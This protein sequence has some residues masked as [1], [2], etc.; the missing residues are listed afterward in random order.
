MTNSG[1]VRIYELSRDLGLPSR[2]ILDA[3]ETRS[4]SVKSHSSSISEGQAETIIGHLVAEGHLTKDLAATYK[5][6]VSRKEK[7]FGSDRPGQTQSASKPTG[8]SLKT[9]TGLASRPKKPVQPST[10]KPNLVAVRSD[11]VQGKDA[12]NAPIALKPSPAGPKLHKKPSKPSKEPASSRPKLVSTSENKKDL[13]RPTVIKAVKAKIV[14]QPPTGKATGKGIAPKGKEGSVVVKPPSVEAKPPQKPKLVRPTVVKPATP[15]IA[16]RSPGV[17]SAKEVRTPKGKASP[18]VVRSSSVVGKPLKPSAAVKRQVKKLTPQGSPASN[19]RPKETNPREKVVSPPVA[20]KPPQLMAP[21]KPAAPQA[22]VNEKPVRQPR[23]RTSPVSRTSTQAPRPTKDQRLRPGSKSTT[24]PPTK[25]PLSAGPSPSRPPQPAKKVVEQHQPPRR[26]SAK[27]PRSVVASGMPRSR[28]SVLA[29]RPDGTRSP[30]SKSTPQAQPPV[31]Q[32]QIVARRPSARP[33]DSDTSQRTGAASG[34]AVAVRSSPAGS[35]RRPNPTEPRSSELLVGRPSRRPS[36]GGPPGVSRPGGGA[37]P[38]RLQGGLPPGVRRPAAPSEVL[39]KE[40][41]AGS[42]AT[43]SRPKQDPKTKT[44]AESP[45]P[46]RRPGPPRG[47]APGGRRPGPGGRPRRQDWDDSARLDQLQRGGA[48][49]KQ[50]TKVHIIGIHDEDVNAGEGF[51]S[52]GSSAVLSASLARPSVKP[53]GATGQPAIKTKRRKKSKETARQR[54]R[55]RAMEL[56][57]ARE[58]K[59]QRPEMLVVPEGNLTV[60]ELAEALGVDSSDIIKSLFFKGISATVTQSLDLPA[61]EKVAEEFG[62]PVVEDDIEAAAK[63]TVAMI[64]DEDLENLSRRPPVVTVMGHVDHGKTSLLDAIRSTRVAAGEAGGITQHIGAYQVEVV[65]EEKP[66]L[67]TFLDTPGHEAF[68]AMRARGTKVT[69]IAVLVVAADDGVR[70]QTI[71]AISHARA[72]EVPI[73]VAINKVDKE[74]ANPDRVRQELADHGLTSEEWGGET[75]MVPVSALRGENIDK[76]LE[77]ILL[78][79][80]IEDLQANPDRLAR[81]TVVEAHLDKAKGPVA[82]LLVQNGTLRPGDVI[83]AGPVLGKIR[84]MVNDRGDRLMEALPSAAVEALGFSEVPTAGDAFEVF[85]DEKAARAVVSDRV[86]DARAARLAQQMASR[87][88]SLTALSDQAAEGELKELNLILK[89][90]VQGSLEAILGSL[91]QLSQEEVQIR[92]LLSSPGEITE[93]DIDLATASGAVVIGFNTSMASGARRAAEAASVDVRNYDVI[94][95]MLEDIQGA[96]EGLLEPEL[97]EEPLGWAEVR[98][99]FSIGNGAVAGCY[100]TE[101]KLQRNCQ[102]RV[103]RG[104]QVVYEGDLD[105]L[106]RIKDGVKEVN[107]GYECG[108]GVSRFTDWKE[109][110]RLEAFSMVMVKRTL[111]V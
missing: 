58:A 39:G 4:I 61:I 95:K 85:E 63:K 83:A 102:L 82:T 29:G 70:P 56:R 73:V 79:S 11:V 7:A 98:A 55:R 37:G 38:E 15:P 33:G 57:Q 101:G 68:T 84:A 100:V 106:R 22:T 2:R 53:Q 80:D 86:S 47:G 21:P 54:Q 59:Q 43:V 9:K 45:T 34:S 111:S 6:K 52:E 107:A 89:T 44:T 50:R 13:Q 104:S 81:G 62:V 76:L 1:K 90:D 42:T 77:M 66:C 60:Q 20:K 46:P 30:Q 99:V 88:V 69:D 10:Q 14:D 36:G 31:R 75:V 74:G 71:E 27:P 35:E 32:P 92:V 64:E 18:S 19:R 110:D 87:R 26:P 94:Y 103:H 23:S 72:A 8:K 67:I 49:S 51:A 12:P 24:V 16:P 65:H 96:M 17:H 93:T 40:A 91:E 41:A 78:V 48:A 108:V 105:S 28:S 97:V 25:P 3:A 5:S 109:G